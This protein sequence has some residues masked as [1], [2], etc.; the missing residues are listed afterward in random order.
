M[1]TL[2]TTCG[3]NMTNG[4]GMKAKSVPMSKAMGVK[5]LTGKL[6][7]SNRVATTGSIKLGLGKK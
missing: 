5:T 3:N 1:K 4:T 2:C 6:A 7:P